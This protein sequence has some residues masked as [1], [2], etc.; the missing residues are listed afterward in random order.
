MTYSPT[1]RR[2]AAVSLL[3]GFL[4]PLLDPTGTLG[5]LA[6]VTGL[7]EAGGKLLPDLPFEP[8]VNRMLAR[9]E[10]ALPDEDFSPA[11]KDAARTFLYHHFRDARALAGR[12][13]AHGENADR[14]VDDLFARTRSFLVKLSSDEQ[15]QVRTL[16]RAFAEA[17]YALPDVLHT[18]EAAFRDQVRH[19]LQHLRDHLEWDVWQRTEDLIGDPRLAWHTVMKA[20]VPSNLLSARYAFV[21]FLGREEALAELQAFRHSPEPF[22]A[23]VVA[24]TGGLGKTRLLQE[25]LLHAHADGWRAGFLGTETTD[26]LDGLKA[27]HRLRQC[28]WLVVDYA[29]DQPDAVGN[30]IASWLG[31]PHPKLRLVLLVRS[32]N[33]LEQALEQHWGRSHRVLDF[34]RGGKVLELDEEGLKVPPALRASVFDHAR[35]AFAA[36]LPSSSPPQAPPAADFFAPPHFENTLY[37]HIAA[38]TAVE[39]RPLRDRKELLKFVL[40]REE[41]HW[42]K[43]LKEDAH[44]KGK[45]TGR[46]VMS[47]LV[48]ATLCMAARPG[49]DGTPPAL[50]LFAT[51][52]KG[53]GVLEDRKSVV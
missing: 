35:Q 51:P 39:D 43:R 11:A 10:D 12:I 19:Q 49:T 14:L 38:L 32:R 36:V 1:A 16:L 42:T 26:L 21:P 3:K 15:A 27:L 31:H 2:E 41:D 40:Q 6:A 25:T 20:P 23:M 53:W 44:V 13:E 47:V 28:V 46:Q 29:E 17:S 4:T 50:D 7:L 22:Q 18:L 45:W 8:Q 52:V 34:L 37:L 48:R 9:I 24:G 5:V 33:L 30:I